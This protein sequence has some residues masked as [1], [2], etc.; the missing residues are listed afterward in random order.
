MY[1]GFCTLVPRESHNY[2]SYLHISYITQPWY[3]DN[4]GALVTFINVELYSNDI[5]RFIL[6]HG[7]YHELSKIIMIVHP[8][9]IQYR[10]CFGLRHRGRCELV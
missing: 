3:T 1:E 7:Y 8:D 6:S 5:K 2:L 9:N 10:E 4:A